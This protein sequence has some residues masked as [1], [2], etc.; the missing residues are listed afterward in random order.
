[1]W[2]NVDALPVAVVI[3]AIL[4]GACQSSTA[5]VPTIEGLSGIHWRMNLTQLSEE[6]LL[7]QA[8]PWCPWHCIKQ[9]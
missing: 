2:L 8:F 7:I 6:R 3:D 1:M 4:H 9:P 5:R